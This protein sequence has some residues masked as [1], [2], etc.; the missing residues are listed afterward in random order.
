MQRFI[1][2][3]FLWDSVD[4]LWGPMEY[5]PLNPKVFHVF[6][7]WDSIKIAMGNLMGYPILTSVGR[8]HG[9]S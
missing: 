3:G 1:L 7:P 5:I 2:L 9:N 6:S 4:I 8:T